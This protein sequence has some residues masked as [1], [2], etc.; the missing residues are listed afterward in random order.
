MTKNFEEIFE[1]FN[2]IMELL[3]NKDFQYLLENY[4]RAK[5]VFFIGYQIQDE[6]S[7]EILFVADGKRD[8]K[9]DDYIHAFNEFVNR[10]EKQ[11]EAIG[12]LLNRPKSWNTNAL[13]ELKNKLKENDFEEVNLRKAHKI[14]YHKN[15]VD[16]ISMIKYA[17]KKQEYLYSIDERVDR[18]INI[19]ISGKNFTSEQLKW[20]NYIKEHLKQNYTIDENDLN[21]LPIFTDHGGL[22]KFKNLFPNNYKDLITEINIAIAA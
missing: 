7:S 19:V 3:R 17:A 5:K 12:I 22:H 8:L 4:E 16:I 1:S 14:V 11:I 18:A 20:I 6:I 9:P 21:D 10:N 13:N 15:L 2:S